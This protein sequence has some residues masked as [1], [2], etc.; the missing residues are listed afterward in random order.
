MALQM[1]VRNN[2]C[3]FVFPCRACEPAKSH[4]SIIL[5][6]LFISW[7]GNHG[8]SPL[9]FYFFL[10]E[11]QPL[12]KPPALLRFFQTS[13]IKEDGLFHHAEPWRC[14]FGHFSKAKMYN[15]N[16][17]VKVFR[18]VFFSTGKK[19]CMAMYVKFFLFKSSHCHMSSPMH[20]NLLSIP[21]SPFS[22]QILA[23][24]KHSGLCKHC[25]V[26]QEVVKQARA[27]PL[28]RDFFWVAL[29]TGPDVIC[30]ALIKDLHPVFIQKHGCAHTGTEHPKFS[31][32]HRKVH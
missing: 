12:K 32:P 23:P 14:S 21:S 16:I 7:Q 20:L 15:F 8:N 18:F 30:R 10:W 26:L 5:L 24:K 29:Y 13:S 17:I 31:S 1:F 28:L 11:K 19:L 3:L 4:G 25:R 6:N 22:T 2:H 27:E 9:S